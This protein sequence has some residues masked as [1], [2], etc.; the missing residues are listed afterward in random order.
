VFEEL[1]VKNLIEIEEYLISNLKFKSV[2]WPITNKSKKKSL[3]HL[4]GP[5]SK[6]LKKS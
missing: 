2:K 4:L 6:K 3:I 1:L 5:L